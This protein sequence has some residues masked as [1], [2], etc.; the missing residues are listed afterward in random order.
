MSIPIGLLIGTGIFALFAARRF[1]GNRIPFWLVVIPLFAT[2]IFGWWGNPWILIDHLRWVLWLPALGI[3]ACTLFVCSKEKVGTG[4]LGIR[5][6]ALGIAMSALLN[7]LKEIYDPTTQV[8]RTEFLW[9]LL[10][11]LSFGAIVAGAWISFR[12]RRIGVDEIDSECGRRST[13]LIFLLMAVLSGG[14]FWTE[15]ASRSVD[16]YWRNHVSKD[17]EL[18]AAACGSST[19]IRQLTGTRADTALPAYNSLKERLGNVVK[20]S[21][22]YR[23]AYLMTMKE[24]KVVFLL[25]SEPRGSKDESVA[26][27]IYTDADPLLYGAFYH[28]RSFV[29]GPYRDQWG[30]WISGYAPVP[31]NVMN[32]L[33]VYLGMD[34]STADWGKSLDRVRQEKML[35]VVVLALFVTG[36]IVINYLSGESRIRQASSEERLR[37]SLQGANLVSWEMDVHSQTMTIDQSGMKEWDVLELPSRLTAQEFLTLVH[38]DDWDVVRKAFTGFF[39]G[40]KKALEAEFRLRQTDGRFLWVISRGQIT[41]GDDSEHRPRAAGLILDISDRKKTELELVRQRTEASRL[42]LVAESA[43]SAVII[44]SLDGQIEWVNAGFTEIT[45]YPFD[46][47]KGKKPG[48]FLQGKNTDPKVVEKI[49]LALTGR[50]GFQE[51]L[52][53]YHK[54]GT[55]YWVAIECQPL[56]NEKGEASGFMAIETDVTRRVEAEKALEDQR[57][58]LQQI[59][60]T[61]LALGENYEEN[62]KLLTDLAVRVLHATHAFYA[63][64][65]HEQLVILAK[66]GLPED[67]PLRLPAAKSLY[68]EVIQGEVHFLTIHDPSLRGTSDPDLAGFQTYIGEG[69]HLAGQVVGSLSLLY[70]HRFEITEDLHDCLLIISQA[71]GKEEM[72]HLNRYK[73]DALTALEATERSRFSTLLKNIDDAVLVENT[74]RQITYAN[75]AFEAMF[76]LSF[77]AIQGL[78]CGEVLRKAATGF[79]NEEGFISTIDE[80]ISLGK[81]S[82]N[83]IHQTLDGQH[84]MRD[85]FPIQ[86]EGIRYGFMW[87]FRNITRMKKHQLLL[88]A[89]GDVGQLLLNTPLNS[90]NAWLALV[91]MLGKK[92]G[93]DRVRISRYQF[94]ADGS[95]KE[96]QVFAEWDKKV[97]QSFYRDINEVGKYTNT[98]QDQPAYW[99]EQFLNGRCVYELG[100]GISS[101]LLKKLGTRS[102][103]SIPISV[104]G[105]LWGTMGFHYGMDSYPWEDEEITLLETVA[106]LIS[107]RLDLQHSEKALVA[108]VNAA[109]AANR[110][111][112]TFLA[113]MS[114]EIRTPLNA[115]IG[116]SSLL[117]ETK[118]DQQ[119]R[120]YAATVAGSGEILLELINDILDYSK[121]EA[122]KIDIEQ[123]PFSISDVL[124]ESLEILARPAAEKKIDLSYACDPSL[125]QLVIGDRTRI[126]QVLLNLVSN[127]VKFTQTGSVSLRA[128]PGGG[129]LIRLM[130]RDTGIGMDE[131]VQTRLFVPFMQADSSVTRKYGGTGLGLAISK[132]LVELMGGTISVHSTPGEGTTFTMDLPLPVGQADLKNA[133][134]PDR[135]LIGKRVLIVDDNPVNRQFL[136]DQLHIWGMNTVEAEGGEAALAL[137]TPHHHFALVLLD[138][139]MPDIDG[140]SLA[141]TIKSLPQGKRLPL[142]LLS[143]VIERVPSDDEALFTAALTKPLRNTQ[144]LEVISAS[145]SVGKGKS[146]GLVDP[147]QA[148]ELRVLV[149]EDNQTNQKVITMMLSRFGVNPVM[150]E[151]GLQALEAVKCKTF[152]L[153]LIDIQMPVMDGLQASR[154]MRKY[155]G[156][157]PRPEIVALTANAF[158]E[159][160]EACLAAGMDGYLVKPITLDRLRAVVEKASRHP[161]MGEGI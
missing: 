156:V 134:A 18:V 12:Q 4:S 81:T 60:I 127:A 46:D 31:G 103:L 37:L 24:G 142:I 72:L 78:S 123:R 16:H 86:N 2:G 29:T 73:L 83:K 5:L 155:F 30:T 93:I 101:H 150:V 55:P 124:I 82:L 57:Q 48:E 44:T 58:R 47:V 61:L 110:A 109:D 108:A 45:G 85:F 99:L 149:A 59:N 77:P 141:R 119:Q 69:V 89:I 144:L 32:G 56:L 152:D 7:P 41:R 151:N 14:W 98:A 126:K 129:S 43:A 70:Q 94:A 40:T 9:A 147:I 137:L 13:L 53:N 6:L 10:P 21:N 67:H 153:V 132:R 105:R 117:L 138:Y 76:R 154:E 112:S 52:L 63:R 50:H 148:S 42:A 122:G 96:S 68:A 131:E 116:V 159:D 128:E 136:R 54:N 20:S 51:T 26:G 27:D 145:L 1:S 135:F 95:F 97:G 11:T 111:K 75:P 121:I 28:P 91:T 65:E 17:A 118:L 33:P 23:F 92:I 74:Q 8:H 84:I 19:Y 25:D 146:R 39:Q 106:S 139:Q 80:T 88:E 120:D 158:K 87:R 102:F 143:S 35:V 49:R 22:G 133:P 100:D 36:L 64:I 107:S 125:P 114:H 130:V 161:T 3:L 15:H 66:A 38:P 115:V 104:A 62:L 71:I 79:L 113:T 160:R 157:G 34:K 90:S 140:L